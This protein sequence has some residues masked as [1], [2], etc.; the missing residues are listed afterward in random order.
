VPDFQ[1]TAQAMLSPFHSF[2]CQAVAERHLFGSHEAEWAVHCEGYT[3]KLLALMVNRYGYKVR[4][5]VRNSW[6]GTYNFELITEKN[7]RQ[8]TRSE[9]QDITAKYLR[10]YLVDE[11]AEAKLLAVWMEIYGDQIQKSF[12]E[13]AER[14]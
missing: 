3:P 1:K 4:K 2:R 10:C 8:I 14:E 6:K 7:S 12:A 9:F 5:L 11:K 13:V